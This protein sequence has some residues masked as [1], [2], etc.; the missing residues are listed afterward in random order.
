M[1]EL[2]KSLAAVRTPTEMQGLA[3]DRWVKV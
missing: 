2:H 3:A 1:L